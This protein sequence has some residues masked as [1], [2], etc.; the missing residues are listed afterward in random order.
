MRQDHIL[1]VRDAQLVMPEFLCEIG[2][3]AH[4]F[5]G[6][7]ARGLPMCLQRDCHYGVS[8]NPMINDIAIDPGAKNR[9]IFERLFN[10]SQIPRLPALRRVTARCCAW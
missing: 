3:G 8:I 9:I 5:G 10:S 4:L 6:G 7:I 1:L 2:H